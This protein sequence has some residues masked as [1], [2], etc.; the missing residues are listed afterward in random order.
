M[1]YI[2][3]FAMLLAA[4]ATTYADDYSYMVFVNADGTAV[5]LPATGTKITFADGQL[6]AVSG[7]ES[8]TL[9][10]STLSYMAFTDEYIA[11]D[12]SVDDE[13][14]AISNVENGNTSVRIANGSIIITA[15]GGLPVS[16]TSM[17]GIVTAR[18][19]TVDSGTTV[20]G[21]NMPAGVYIVRV[22][23]KSTKL[24]VK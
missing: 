19:I 14:T 16:V 8:A 9:D 17:S 15:Q 22:N 2:L 24:V 1:R 11:G 20:L 6:T 12:D 3:S 5:Y 13:S 10:L 4:A 7:E 23:G 21:D 18:G